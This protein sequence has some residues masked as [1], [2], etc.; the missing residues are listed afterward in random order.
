MSPS[1]PST[2]P[3]VSLLVFCSL[4]LTGCTVQEMRE[5]REALE[6]VNAV[7]YD[8]YSSSSDDYSSSSDDYSSSSDDYRDPSSSRD[9]VSSATASASE[10]SPSN[11][12][13]HIIDRPSS[14]AFFQSR[15]QNV[16]NQKVHVTYGFSTELDGTPIRAPWCTPGQGGSMGG[17]ETLSPGE[18]QPIAPIDPGK[19]Y[20][21]FWCA[22]SDLSSWAA[23]AEPTGSGV[24]SCGCRCAPH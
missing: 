20:T 18:H 19:G 10:P 23:F 5:V 8:D 6:A 13:I 2:S 17:A 3:V 21:V 16:C 24:D 4:S 22:C 14:G 7:I 1:A 12:C 11:H 9:S 15:M